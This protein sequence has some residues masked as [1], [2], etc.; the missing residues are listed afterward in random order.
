MNCLFQFKNGLN[1]IGVIT[2]SLGG[3]PGKNKA[4]RQLR[5]ALLEVRRR[6]IVVFCAGGQGGG[7]PTAFLFNA[8]DLAPFPAT[9][10]NTIGVS[11][12][13]ITD[14]PY[15]IGV[16]GQ[17]IKVAA[18]G[19]QVWRAATTRNDALPHGRDFFVERSHGSSYATAI[20]AG[21]CAL[22][23]SR[24]GRDKLIGERDLSR[25][26]NTRKPGL[27]PP[28]HLMTA[29]LMCLESTARKPVGFDREKYGCGII[30]AKALLDFPLP[31]PADVKVEHLKKFPTETSP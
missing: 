4:Y 29:F 9:D 5:N 25:A 11:A 12:C 3:P 31:K 26:G 1:D 21:V 23:Q 19:D 10:P 17:H 28:Q 7:A 20:A 15:N 22:W 16:H 18:P 14:A 2:M 24:W 13:E 6:G 8:I 27:Y 30:D